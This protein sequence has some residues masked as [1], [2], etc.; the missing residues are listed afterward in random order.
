MSWWSTAAER[1]PMTRQN[2]HI[3]GLGYGFTRSIWLRCFGPEKRRR[4]RSPRPWAPGHLNGDGSGWSDRVQLRPTGRRT[5]RCTGLQPQVHEELLDHRLFQ[6]G[7][8]ELQLTAA[9]RAVRQVDL[10]DALEQPGPAQPHRAMVRTVR[11][12]LGRW[13]YLSA[14]RRKCLKSAGLK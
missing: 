12:A 14:P 9:A 13:R 8:D 4:R 7:S 5:R 11:L 10:E 3:R 2:M 6:D 1:V